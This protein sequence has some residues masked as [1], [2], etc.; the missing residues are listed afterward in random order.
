[1]NLS[2]ASTAVSAASAAP[3]PARRRWLAVDLSTFTGAS[4]GLIVAFA[5]AQMVL[6]TIVVFGVFGSALLD[7]V[8]SRL[9]GWVQDTLIVNLGILVPV[10]LMLLLWLGG[11]RPRAIG[12]NGRKA[13]A[14]LGL[15]A[16]LWAAIQGIGLVVAL[17]GGGGL[18][19]QPQWAERG[20]AVMVGALLAQLFGNALHEEIAYR[21]FLLNHV[22]ARL[23][24]SLGDPRRAQW[25]GLLASQ[26]IFALIHVPIRLLTGTPLPRLAL[27]LVMLVIMGAL[28]ALIYHRTG[29]LFVAVGVHALFNAPTSLFLPPG[30][31]TG[32][33]VG[34]TAVLLLAWPRLS[35]RAFAPAESAA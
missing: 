35:P 25:V 26:A 4:W 3:K 17:I 13:L 33:V 11:L 6:T 23:R 31:A 29:N 1:M 24:D 12:L 7:P 32:L 30:V 19:L 9:G 20:V 27:S 15:T 2:P 34:L 5:L 18:A 14:G 16:A 10:D 22:I 21:G 8:T 28:F